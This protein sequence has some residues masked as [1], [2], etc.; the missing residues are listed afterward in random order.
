MST[1]TPYIYAVAGQIVSQLFAAVLLLVL[2][3]ILLWIAISFGVAIWAGRKVEEKAI[4]D[5]L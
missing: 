2:I 3:G 4:N 5:K 1:S